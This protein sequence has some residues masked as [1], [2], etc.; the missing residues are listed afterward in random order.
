M[1]F[2]NLAAIDLFKDIVNVKDYQAFHDLLLLN[3][4]DTLKDVPSTAKHALHSGSRLLGYTAYKIIEGYIWIFI[5]DITEKERLESIAE[6]VNI[7]ENAGYIFSGIRHELGNPINSIKM[8][9]SVLKNNLDKFP[10]E[11]TA[12]YIDRTLKEISRVEYLLKSLKNFSMYESPHPEQVDLTAFMEKFLSLTEDYFHSKGIEI[13][14]LVAPHTK[15]G[16]IDPRAFQQVMMNLMSNAVD[17]LEGREHPEIIIYMHKVLDRIWINIADNGCGMT[18]EQQRNLFKPFYTSKPHGTGL[19]MVIV[20]KM[21]AKMNSTIEVKSFEN[22]GTLVTISLPGED[23][24]DFI[25]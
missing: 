3:V 17:A 14:T 20:K 6:A 16:Y 24:D 10:S 5:R 21:L 9:L 1:L 11:T 12:Q 13:K 2:Q 25:P 23:R 8:T 7:M 4:E 15:W 19:G 22:S 18:E